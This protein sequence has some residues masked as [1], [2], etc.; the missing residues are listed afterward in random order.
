MILKQELQE[1]GCQF[2]I[3]PWSPFR[4]V[5]G[6]L[7]ASSSYST[8][9]LLGPSLASVEVSKIGYRKQKT[10]S[11]HTAVFI[12]LLPQLKMKLKNYIGK[13]KMHHQ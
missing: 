10:K 11:K 1:V 8:V 9:Q 3:W 5:I 12:E 13:K 6:V 7:I 2:G 4:L